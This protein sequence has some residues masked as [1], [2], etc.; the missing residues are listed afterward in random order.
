MK[1]NSICIPCSTRSVKSN[2]TTHLSKISWDLRHLLT[3]EKFCLWW[4]FSLSSGSAGHFW[5]QQNGWRHVVA[6]GRTCPCTS[7]N[8]DRLLAI[9][10]VSCWLWDVSPVITRW[11]SE[12]HVIIWPPARWQSY[13]LAQPQ[14]KASS[15]RHLGE[16][17][18][19]AYEYIWA[20]PNWFYS[21]ETKC[22]T[23]CTILMCLKWSKVA[24][25]LV[26]S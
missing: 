26:L 6:F 19:K 13:P 23:A 7:G 25:A 2:V 17:K 9:R 8:K 11:A 1:L 20:Y 22:S 24:K 14:H 18:N 15:H 10:F 4:D 3:S 12:M 5:Q 16:K 21:F